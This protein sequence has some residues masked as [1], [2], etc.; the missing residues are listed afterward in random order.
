MKIP[1]FSFHGMNPI[2]REEAFESFKNFFDSNWYVLGK[3]TTS[4]ETEFALFSGTKYCIGVSNGLE[5]L[6]L[7]LR[8]LGL[9]KN[10]EVIVP[11]NTYI[12]TWLAVS[13]TGATIVPVEPNINTYNIDPEKIETAITEKTKVIMPVHL[14]GQP[15]EMDQI[16]MIAEKYKIFVVE[17]NAQAQGATYKKKR[18]GSFGHINGVS[19]YP[20]KNLGALGEAGAITT[21]DEELANKIKILRNY[22][23]Q[24]KYYNEVIGFNSR[25]DEAQAGILS[26]KL[27]YIDS[28]NMERIKL[29]TFYNTCLTG[30]DDITIPYTVDNANSVFHQY[31]IRTK[32]RDKLKIYLESIGIETMIHYPIPPHLQKAY[33]F[34]RFKKSDF[35]IAEEISNTVLSLPIY[36]GLKESEV[37]YISYNIRKFFN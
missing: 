17:D 19:F 34:L 2:F 9:S 8:A 29:A 21:D 11:S 7:S 31:I 25:I 1:F 14:Y 5:A 13:Y 28:W 15:C 22:G 26:V 37:E 12:A 16:M 20:G 6:H 36:P 4:F 3:N 30:L 24:K 33:E 10:D 35:P 32:F 23:S 18:T 27:K